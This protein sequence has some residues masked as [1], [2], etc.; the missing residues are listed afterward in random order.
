MRKKLLLIGFS[1]LFIFA[2]VRARASSANPADDEKQIRDVEAQ[3]E[4]AWNNHDAAGLAHL[5][6]PDADMINARGAW[7]K[8]RDQMEKNQIE[9]QKSN[10]R[11]SV[12]KTNEVDV[13][14]LTPD[15]AVVHVYWVL[16]N[17]RNNDGVARQPSL[18]VFTRTDIKRDGHWLIA[19]SQATYVTTPAAGSGE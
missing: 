12:W 6:T 2:A 8:G 18:G 14:F 19:A 4:T 5:L 15:V 1:F 16:T 7:A 17:E 9:R 10:E 13:R 11:D 3:W